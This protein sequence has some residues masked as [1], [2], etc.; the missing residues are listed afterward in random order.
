M[1]RWAAWILISAAMVALFWWQTRPEPISVTVVT[2]ERGLVE[3]TVANTRAGTVKACKRAKLSLPVGGQ[4]ALLPVQEGEHVEANTVLMS[5]WN[6]D[7]QA[8][9]QQARMAT[10]SARLEQNAVCIRARNLVREADR[11]SRLSK[12]RLVSVERVDQARTA[13]A[14]AEA[15]CAAAESREQA[16]KVALTVAQAELEKT[17]LRAPFAG[18]VA[19]VTG[20][21]GE[22]A[23]PSPPGIAT[24]PAIDLL[25]DDCHYVVAPIDEVDAGE[26]ALKLPVRISFDAYPDQHFPGQL[27]RIAPYVLDLEKQA[28]TVEVEVDFT[29]TPDIPLFAGYSADVEI[30][31]QN[32]PDTLRIP[33]E[34]LLERE[35]VLI[36]R[37]GEPLRKQPIRAGISNWRYTEVL[38]GLSEGDQVVTSL[39]RDQ[40]KAGAEA[41]ADD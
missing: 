10:D 20:E 41:V 1:G 32:R 34:A 9:E 17:F 19:E 11:L 21:V 18:I 39:G 28:R 24:P 26:L 35:F 12:Q 33:T 27:R 29:P 5:L 36:Y 16:A 23:T 7:L 2:V 37:A 8:K 4:I 40:V 15:S 30:V 6:K 38:E 31:L 25:T 14:A 13:A 3:R 22:F